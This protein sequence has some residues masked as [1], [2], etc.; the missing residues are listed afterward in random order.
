MELVFVFDCTRYVLDV[1]KCIV[2]Y[3]RQKRVCLLSC[4]QANVSVESQCGEIL[5]PP[6]L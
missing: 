2:Y 3:Q 5:T 4:A 1:V 6:S